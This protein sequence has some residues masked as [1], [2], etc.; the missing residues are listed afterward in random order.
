MLLNCI[1]WNCA[2]WIPKQFAIFFTPHCRRKLLRLQPCQKCGTRAG[3]NS[4]SSTLSSLPFL[5]PPVGATPIG[6]AQLES[7]GQGVWGMYPQQHRAGQR[8]LE[9]VLGS[10][11]EGRITSTHICNVT[12]H[13]WP[14]RVTVPTSDLLLL[15][16]PADLSVCTAGR[17]HLP[18][19]PWLP[20][21]WASCHVHGTS[22]FACQ[23]SAQS[24]LL[25]TFYQFLP[26]SILIDWFIQNS[27]LSTFEVTNPVLGLENVRVNK[28][29]NDH[30]PF[31][32]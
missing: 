25:P 2:V 12:R 1:K 32:A 18:F 29:G 19:L 23:K 9:R 15:H 11:K 3:K 30:G 13:Q 14:L 21:R 5:W 4:G 10:G 7:R 20:E 26:F 27:L 16:S 24:S 17:G 31:G 6:W 28:S 22:A 8:R